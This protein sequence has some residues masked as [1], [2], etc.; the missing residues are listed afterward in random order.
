M[1]VV[2]NDLV[3][4][5]DCVPSTTLALVCI[6]FSVTK[7]SPDSMLQLNELESHLCS[8]ISGAAEAQIFAEIFTGG[9]RDMIFCYSV[10]SLW[11]SSLFFMPVWH[12]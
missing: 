4:L 7:A 5:H 2:H 1:P 8:Q 11:L 9:Y 6:F 10:H 12:Q 3:S